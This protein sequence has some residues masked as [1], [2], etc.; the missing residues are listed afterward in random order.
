MTYIWHIYDIYMSY[1]WHI[2]DIYMNNYE[3]D[4]SLMFF[5]P[6]SRGCGRCPRHPPGD[7]ARPAGGGGEGLGV[8]GT[9][10]MRHAA[11]HG[12][13][14]RSIRYSGYSPVTYER[15]DKPR[16]L[17]V[18][19]F[20]TNPSDSDP[21]SWEFEG[22]KSQSTWLIMPISRH[23]RLTVIPGDMLYHGPDGETGAAQLA[24]LLLCRSLVHRKVIR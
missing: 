17:G 2:Y 24:M 13:T 15:D 6:K 7:A 14:I 20:H 10:A 11:I 9:W 3:H 4:E 16:I 8:W 21:M 19:N 1:I 12:Y 22:L 5:I 18:P 23:A